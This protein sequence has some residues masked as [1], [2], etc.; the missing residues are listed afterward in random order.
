MTF[1]KLI[2]EGT[3]LAGQS[4]TLVF[5]VGYEPDNDTLIDLIFNGG[6]YA[7]TAI[8]KALDNKASSIDDLVSKLLALQCD[9][10][11]WALGEL[12]DRELGRS[13]AVAQSLAS[14]NSHSANSALQKLF[15]TSFEPSIGVIEALNKLKAPKMRY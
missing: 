3:P 15:S 2:A 8:Q 9:R 6:E 4:L 13:N 10:A 11:N 1:K 14:Q 5:T 7:D 12:F